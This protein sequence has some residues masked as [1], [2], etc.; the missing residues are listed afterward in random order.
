ML[1]ALKGNLCKGKEI[2]VVSAVILEVHVMFGCRNGSV[3]TYDFAGY[4]RKEVAGLLI[5]AGADLEAAN[6]AGQKPA[7][8]AKMNRE[9]G[10]SKKDLVL[11]P[12]M[13]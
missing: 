1:P 9:V 3:H 10:V 8:A 6:K 4:G 5:A 7:D 12:R 11:M 2:C 13:T